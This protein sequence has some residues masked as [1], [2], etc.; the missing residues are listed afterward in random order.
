FF[1]LD[2]ILI[3]IISRRFLDPG[4]IQ[5]H[6]YSVSHSLGREVRL[7][8]GSD[9]ARVA[10]WAGHLAP[11]STQLGFFATGTSGNWCPLLSSVHI[12]AMLASI[13]DCIITVF[14]SFNLEESGVLVLVA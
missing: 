12:D 7:E 6:S 13:K 1:F 3:L 5:H 9:T 4:R 2:F 10:M 14:C 8:L 11:D